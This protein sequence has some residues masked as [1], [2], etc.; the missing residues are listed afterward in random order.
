MLLTRIQRDREGLLQALE[1]VDAEGWEGPTARNLLEQIRR[2]VVIPLVQQIGLHGAAAE[3]AQA[4]GWAIAWEVLSARSTR[5]AVSPW[6]VI[7]VAVRRAILN[8]RMAS[9]YAT[10][11][12]EAWRLARQ[13]N[14]GQLRPVSIDALQETGW[15]PASEDH[16]TDAGVVTFVVDLL[17]EVGW[18]RGPAQVLMNEIAQAAPWGPGHGWRRISNE[19]GAEQWQVRRLIEALAGDSDLTLANLM[20]APGNAELRTRFHQLLQPTMKKRSP[21]QTAA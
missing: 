14:E 13:D 7:W 4:T 11:P 10:A 18:D 8:E 1:A 5:A 3:Q 2:S 6:G 15:E 9:M 16:L 21:A 19:I 12:R 17:V 20:A